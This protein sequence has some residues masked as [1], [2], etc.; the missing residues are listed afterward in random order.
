MNPKGL[1]SAQAE[2]V[3]ARDGLNALSPPRTTPEWVKF[4]KNLFGGFALLLWVGALL[5]YVAFTVDAMTLEHPSKD[6]VI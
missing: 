1:T 5:C 4:C 6:N 3:L 2:K